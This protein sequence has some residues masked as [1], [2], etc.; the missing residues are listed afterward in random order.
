V[1]R[2]AGKCHHG[3]V[4]TEDLAGQHKVIPRSRYTDIKAR[5]VGWEGESHK[6]SAEFDG[7]GGAIV[8]AAEETWVVGESASV[9][10]SF[11]YSCDV[12]V[13][14]TP[15]AHPDHELGSSWESTF[16]EA[17]LQSLVGVEFTPRTAGSLST[18]FVG[19]LACVAR[20]SRWARS[21]GWVRHYDY[22]RGWGLAG[23]LGTRSVDS[24][25][26]IPPHTALDWS[27]S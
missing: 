14:G 8:E 4:T 24:S 2:A 13:L 12:R 22:V 20:G 23:W 5:G 11:R 3:S 21:S 27:N 6:A 17:P 18:A 15:E 16:E 7:K 26:S 25:A 9:N 1:G 19:Y 10:P